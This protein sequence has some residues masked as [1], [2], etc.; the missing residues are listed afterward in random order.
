M[1]RRREKSA[2]RGRQMTMRLVV[3]FLLVGVTSLHGQV[4]DSVRAVEM[5]R[6]EALLAADTVALSRMLAPDF[7]EISRLGTVRTR[8]DNVRDIASG[9]LHLTSISYDSLNVR[10]YGDVAVLTGIADNTGTMRGFPFSGRIRYTRV[11]VRRDGRWQAVLM[12]Q[13]PIQ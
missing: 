12:Q 3:L 2:A 1:R 13:T 6:R 10:V 4:E 5:R 8:A 11:F 9:A 7:M